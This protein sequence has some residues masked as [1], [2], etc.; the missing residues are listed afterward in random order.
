MIAAKVDAT[1]AA[2][3]MQQYSLFRSMEELEAHVV[4]VAASAEQVDE[5]TSCDIDRKRGETPQRPSTL[6][7]SQTNDR[8]NDCR[9]HGRRAGRR[10]DDFQ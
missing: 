9:T 2:S 6:A 1:V 10:T 5:E 7:R 4:D 3:F 8:I